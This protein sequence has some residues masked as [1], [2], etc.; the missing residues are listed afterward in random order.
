[1]SALTVLTGARDLI[2]AGWVQG[3]SE[4]EVNGQQCY[5]SV[6]AISQAYHM[7]PTRRQRGYSEAMSILRSVIDDDSVV[8]WNDHPERTQAMVVA[9]F[10]R[11]I[12]I[13]A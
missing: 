11:A 5:C 1:M 13:A 2:A 9:G 10:D 7:L 4:R 12:K 3:T 8:N 6:G